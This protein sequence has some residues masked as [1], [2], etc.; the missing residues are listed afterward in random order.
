MVSAP[1]ERKNGKPMKI[2]VLAVK[3][4]I[5]KSILPT[6]GRFSRARYYYIYYIQL[7]YII[8][9]IYNILLLYVYTTVLDYIRYIYVYPCIISDIYMCILVLYQIYII[10]CILVLYQIYILCVSLYYIRYIYVYPC[11]IAKFKEKKIYI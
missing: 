11:I 10:M 1:Y 2:A 8:S 6:Y 9:D 5:S 4:C 3:A 7:Y